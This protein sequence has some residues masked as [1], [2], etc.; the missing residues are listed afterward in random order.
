MLPGSER[1]HRRVIRD[2]ANRESLLTE[3]EN[4]ISWGA[5]VPELVQG[6]R[7]FIILQL[8]FF[9]FD[10]SYWRMDQDSDL[11]CKF[12]C[13]KQGHVTC[14][15][16]GLFLILWVALLLTKLNR[17]QYTQPALPAALLNDAPRPP[18]RICPAAPVTSAPVGFLPLLTRSSHTSKNSLQPLKTRR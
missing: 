2:G 16:Y 12:Q 9:F 1:R 10:D 3:M 15:K 11:V 13:P 4:Q 17:S 5:A 7:T 18:A 8:F 14:Y 6:K